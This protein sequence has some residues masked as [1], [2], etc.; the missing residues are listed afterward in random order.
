MSQVMPLDEIAPCLKAGHPL[1]Q[2]GNALVEATD[3]LGQSDLASFFRAFCVPALFDRV[4]AIIASDDEPMAAAVS[5]IDALTG[6]IRSAPV[7]G[8]ASS[9]SGKHSPEDAIADIEKRTGDHYGKLFR[10]FADTSY[11]DEPKR[12]LAERLERNG[13]PTS[14]LEGKHVLDAGCGGGR[15]TMALKLLGAGSV[16]GADI[17]EPGL[18]D[19]RQRASAANVEGVEFV[20][21][22]MLD[23][24]FD[25]DQFDVVF[26]N[27]VL[28]HTKSWSDGIRELLRVLRPGG[29]G[30]LYL[31]E[32][33]GGLFWDSIELLRAVMRDEQSAVARRAL[34]ALG[35][36]ANRRFYMLDHV[37]VPINV[38]L[39]PSEIEAALRESGAKEIRR[40]ERG[41]DFDRVEKIH[42]ALPHA[43]A[44]FGVGENRFVFTK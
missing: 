1:S 5:A 22:N 27:G 28:H 16:V 9:L 7:L 41:T 2:A 35:I 39:T 4:E 40:L 11:W 44:K 21:A 33:P 25:S 10:E 29:L 17:S 3:A 37:M 38:R 34:T 13:I 23:L 31:I 15:Y 36:P 14:A 24:P 32:N 42:Q 12:L 43:E 8:L 19:A 18:A 26:S 30:W 20:H 6:V